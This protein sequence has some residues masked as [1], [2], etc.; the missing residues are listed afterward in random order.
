MERGAEDTTRARWETRMAEKPVAAS[1]TPSGFDVAPLYTPEDVRSI[2]FAHDIGY[3]GEF[4]FTRGI[5]PSMYRGRLWTFREYSGFG[6]AED[7]NTR[8]RSL[9]Q[10]GMTGLSVALDLPTQIGF[11][12]DD[13]TVRDEVGRVGVAID[14]LADMERL[15]EG[16]PLDKVSTNFT[17]N[18]TSAPILAMYMAV[19]AQQ[20]VKPEHL[21]GTL[22]ND[23]LKEYIAR[24]TWLFPVDAAL[25][26]TGDVIDFCA[27][28]VPR[29]NPISVSGSHMQQ[30]GATPVESVALAFVH[31]LAYID[32]LLQRGLSIDDFAPRI[33]WNLGVVGTDLFEEAARFRA[34]RR[35]WARLVQERYQ[36][37][38]PASCMLR[39]YAGSGGNTLTVEEPLNNIVRVAIEV[40]ASVLGGAQAVHACSYDEAYAIPTEEAQLIALRTQQIIGYEAGLTRTADP[41]AGSYYV[42][43]LTNAAEQKMR[44]IIDEVMHVGV[45]RAIE[46]GLVQERI[47]RSALSE[48][49]RLASGEKV[50]VGVNK[51]RQT[52]G[53]A[54][55]ELHRADPEVYKRQVER[56]ERVRRERHAGRVEAAL[57][58]LAAAAQS[59]VN[60]MPAMVEAVQAYATIGEICKTLT[61]VFGLYTDPAV[62][63]VSSHAS[64]GLQS[65]K[66][67]E[68]TQANGTKIR[69]L[70]AKPGLDGHDRG[71][72][73]MALM[74]RDAG[75]EVIYTGIR[76]SVDAIV[77]A[78][79]QEDVDMIGLSVLSGAHLGLTEHLMARLREQGMD[80]VHVVVGG[81]IPESDIESLKALGAAAVFPGGTPFDVI[82]TKL[83]SLVATSARGMDGSSVVDD[84][85]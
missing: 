50:V 56:T 16:I 61:A 80:D 70:V 55:I 35:L 85:E 24:G 58:Q 45:S 74:L 28:E 52:A 20:G 79:I 51:F 64:S 71:A 82:V 32:L 7:T 25:R 68:Q 46:T 10:Q 34:A 69:M 44:E 65:F 42:E 23:P 2:D 9:L 81:V 12:S 48:E 78:A 6:T 54:P 17:I 31:A 4:P 38:N 33:S 59:D 29:F 11:D 41:L 26:L 73:T 53:A 62:S 40:M 37:Q 63:V 19:G 14:T 66:S 18:T 30:A 27:R 77:Q 84:R 75:M 3:P 43:S 21:R 22:Q 72:K 15:F 8:Y 36:P 1:I 13:P 67:Q 83:R 76:N 47:M 60:I 39:F 57:K 49:Q 5:Y